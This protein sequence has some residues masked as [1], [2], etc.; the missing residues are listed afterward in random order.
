MRIIINSVLS[1]RS[2][3]MSTTDFT[4]CPGTFN[5]IACNVPNG[6]YPLIIFS[7]FGT[8]VYYDLTSRYTVQH[9]AVIILS[10]VISFFVVITAII[11]LV[12]VCVC[13]RTGGSTSKTVT[14]VHYH[15]NNQPQAIAPPVYTN[16]PQYNSMVQPTAPTYYH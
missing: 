16:I 10:V 7:R 5:S 12:C 1:E 8:F 15:N 14:Y 9:V 2:S 6:K 13:R 4:A 3:C 11:V